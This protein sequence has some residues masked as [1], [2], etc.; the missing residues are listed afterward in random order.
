MDWIDLCKTYTLILM[1]DKFVRLIV[2]V[3]VTGVPEPREDH[4]ILMAR[5]A[6]VI[7]LKMSIVASRLETK[8]GPDTGDLALRV[9]MHS[10]PVT[11][12]VL[13]GERAV[14]LNRINVWSDVLCNFLP[15][16]KYLF[17][18]FNDAG[19][20]E[21]LCKNRKYRTTR[22]GASVA[23]GCRLVIQRRESCVVRTS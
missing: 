23:G 3:A 4:A 16:V 1:T 22:A 9:D 19:S 2:S 14:C 7:I 15:N 5:F 12:G 21:Y 11:A 20:V 8:L 6:R 10:G 18:L 13:R 17:L